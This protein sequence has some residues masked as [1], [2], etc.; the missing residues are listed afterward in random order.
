M[1]KILLTLII[2]NL[3]FFLSNNLLKDTCDFIFIFEN[4][5]IGDEMVFEAL[6]NVLIKLIDE[7]YV[8]PEIDIIKYIFNKII[9]FNKIYLE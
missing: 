9:N 3:K 8:Y 2:N 5:C 1:D 7:N 4:Y 6:F